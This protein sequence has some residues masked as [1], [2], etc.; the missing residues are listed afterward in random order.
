M[1]RFKVT[2]KQTV[3]TTYTWEV[4]ADS[5]EDAEESAENGVPDR[6][7]K[8]EH[9]LASEV[10]ATCAHADT[11]CSDRMQAICRDCNE[12]LGR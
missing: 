11:Y 8:T 4:E 9:T 10:E 7:T 2:E 1:A 3:V 5:Q 12:E 6:A